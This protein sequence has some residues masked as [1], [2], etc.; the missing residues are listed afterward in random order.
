MIKTLLLIY[1]LMAAFIVKA[2]TSDKV[3]PA[4]FDEALLYKLYKSKCDSLRQSKKLNA[5]LP[6]SILYKAA[7]MHANYL[8]LKNAEGHFENSNINRT[9]F[10]RV[11]NLGGGDFEVVGENQLTTYLFQPIIFF[12]EKKEIP[13]TLTGY[14]ETAQHLFDMFRFSSHHYE[15]LVNKSF[16]HCAA[17]IIYNPTNKS[18]KMVEVFGSKQK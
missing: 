10:D 13:H 15:N 11:I 3:N 12:Y 8:V 17:A 14:A 4:E 16:T 2:Q 5:L 6:D 18:L 1:I 7:L 9:P